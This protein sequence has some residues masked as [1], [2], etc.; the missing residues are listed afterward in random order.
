MQDLQSAWLLLL[1]C[2]AP[3]R[4]TSSALHPD[5]T[6]VFAAQHIC[7]IRR[8]LEQLL[9]TT[10]PD[11]SWTVATLPLAMG[12]LGL[13]SASRGRKVSFLS[14]WA[15]VL[16][17]ISDHD[18]AAGNGWQANTLPVSLCPLQRGLG[19]RTLHARCTDPKAAPWPGFVSPVALLRSTRWR[20]SPLA[21][22]R[23]SCCPS[24]FHSSGAPGVPGAP[25]PSPLASSSS[26]QAHLRVWPSS[27]LFWP[28][29]RSVPQRG[30][31]GSPRLRV[32]IHC[33]TCVPGSWRPRNS[34]PARPGLGHRRPRRRRQSE[35]GGGGG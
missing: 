12:G 19:F 4:I 2:A 18:I 1:F 7:S 28:P 3:C 10:V 8:C 29:P 15:D 31:V 24:S 16:H 6:R 23:F 5:V 35:T 20:P 25:P 26:H 33:S 34:Q 22:I 17:M 30:S 11:R 9:H 14:S 27:R 32:G 21:G 13:R